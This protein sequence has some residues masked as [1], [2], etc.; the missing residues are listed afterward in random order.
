MTFPYVYHASYSELALPDNHRFPINKYRDLYEL[1]LKRGIL[2]QTRC[3]TPDAIDIN[4]LKQ[5]HCPDYVDS[6]INGTLTQKAMR[7]IGFPWSEQLVRRSL[8]AVNGTKLCVE[9]A[10]EHNVAVNLTGGYH[11]AHYDFGSGFCIFND[12]VIAAHHAIKHYQLDKVLI[13]D[14]DVH[15]GDGTAT[16]CQSVPEIITCS[17]HCAKNFPARKQISDHDIELENGCNDSEYLAILSQSLPLLIAM[18]QPQL[19]IYDAGVDIHQD[20]DLGY[21]AISTQG[22]MQRDQLIM[23]LAQSQQIPVAAVIGGGYSRN[24][25]QLAERHYQLLSAINTTCCE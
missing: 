8:H 22:L 19:I 13:I 6:F 2:E 11:H 18:H 24:R 1:G 21:A 5:V 3:V 17:I 9:L 7:R 25:Q 23:Q 20:D 14:C 15:Q 10:L 16:L 4:E 12:L